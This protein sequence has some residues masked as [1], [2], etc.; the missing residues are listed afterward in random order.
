MSVAESCGRVIGKHVSAFFKLCHYTLEKPRQYQFEAPN[1][2]C[3]LVQMARTCLHITD[4]EYCDLLDF[5][6]SGTQ[7]ANIT[8]W[9]H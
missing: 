4:D 2:S 7:D 8:P 9:L 6:A 3:L 5:Y 1:P